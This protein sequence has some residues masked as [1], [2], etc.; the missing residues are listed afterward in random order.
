[1]LNS[2]NIVQIS[3]AE[4]NRIKDWE[5]DRLIEYLV[6]IYGDKIKQA[7]SA[8]ILVGNNPC[9]L[10]REI[11]IT[12]LAFAAIVNIGGTQKPTAG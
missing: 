4:F 9:Q 1:M 7:I 11:S 5:H 8:T 3:R 6:E 12:L 2:Q 10:I